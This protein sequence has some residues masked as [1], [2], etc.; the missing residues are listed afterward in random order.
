M[1][2]SSDPPII[3]TGGG[4]FSLSAEGEASAEKSAGRSAKNLI[5]I[6]CDPE[7]PK[8]PKRFKTKINKH[9]DIT[10]VLLE[11][12]DMPGQEPIIISGYDV[13]NIKIT[14]NT[15]DGTERLKPK[16]RKRKGKKSA[17]K[18]PAARKSK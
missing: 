7:N 6:D 4:G 17:A 16:P 8:G 2:I 15:D 1:P 18:R 12:P 5:Q 11:F 3:V 14:F 10:S 9:A 13:Y